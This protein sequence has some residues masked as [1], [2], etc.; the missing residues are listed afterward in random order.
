MRIVGGKNR[1]RILNSPEGLT[2]RPTSDRARQ[3]VF[4][5]LMHAGWLGGD[6]LEDAHVIDL[7][8]G[9]GA[10]GLEALSRGGADCVFVERDRHAL[11]ALRQNIAALKAESNST[12]IAA[13]AL[14]LPKRAA[15]INLRTLAFLDPPYNK[16]KEGADAGR[17]ALE[18]LAAR[19]W[20]A[21]GCVCVA[22]MAKKF[23][24]EMPQGFTLRDERPYGVAL[25][26][27]MTYDG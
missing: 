6:A 19:G 14:A 22:E 2:T 1:G 8:A 24:E 26:R 3:A 21:G 16:A 5:I 25:V 27:F 4:N 9:T 15:D 10:L 18:L 17:H 23:P 13:D 20:L 11:T 12:V 7:F